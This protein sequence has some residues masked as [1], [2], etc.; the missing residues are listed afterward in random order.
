[1][2]RV[3]LTGA[4]GFVG[5]HCLPELLARGYEVHAASRR[6]PADKGDEIAWQQI[7][8]LDG[9]Q[10]DELIASLRPT[11]LLH[12]A[13]DT[14]PGLYWTSSDNLRW[15]QA[16]LDLV[17]SFA[18]HGGRRVVCA[19]TCAEYDWSHGYCC[20]RATPLVPRTLYGSC[21]HALRLMAES[22]LTQRQISF[23]WGRL[24]F[25][26]GPHEHPQRFVPSVIRALLACQPAP[27][28][29]GRQLRDFLHVR[30]AAAALTA[31][32]DSELQGPVN[33]ASGEPV[34]LKD[35][36]LR[37]GQQIGLPDLVQLDRIVAPPSEP[38]VL[39]ANVARLTHELA[40]H[41]RLGLDE[42]LRQTIDWWRTIPVSDAA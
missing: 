9:R 29:H 27:C 19:G 15:V 34:A 4:G 31:L 32:L 37:V 21:K 7:D 2:K 10:I 18:R 17:Q 33:I 25:L 41:P 28:T 14:R 16:S 1:M 12:L 22:Y 35:V 38:P 8:L 23:A 3:L 26:F 36:A 39:L 6:P 5:R 40:W 11:H 13:W 42:G 30:D 24:F 20:E